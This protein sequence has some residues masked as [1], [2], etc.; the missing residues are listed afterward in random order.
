MGGYFRGAEQMKIVAIILLVLAFSVGSAGC[1]LSTTLDQGITR[2]E[3]A[4]GEITRKTQDW[5]CLHMSVRQWQLT[6]G[7]SNDLADMW[8]VMCQA[9][10]S[11]P[12]LKP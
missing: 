9:V 3:N 11:P 12:I 4:S 8:K 5:N 2:L 6:F 10:R 1:T 7:S